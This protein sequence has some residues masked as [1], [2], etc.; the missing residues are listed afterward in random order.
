MK[1]NPSNGKENKGS[2][3]ATKRNQELKQEQA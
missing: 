3:N 2:E 1:W